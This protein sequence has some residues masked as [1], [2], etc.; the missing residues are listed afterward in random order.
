M[1]SSWSEEQTAKDG[2]HAR[3]PQTQAFRRALHLHGL[4]FRKLAAVSK[5]MNSHWASF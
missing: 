3:V 1:R 4:E 2:G 5:H